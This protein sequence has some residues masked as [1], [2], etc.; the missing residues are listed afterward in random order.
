MAIS[1]F[2]IY[3]FDYLN[4]SGLLTAKGKT[5]KLEQISSILQK[6]PGKRF[7]LI[8]DDTQNDIRIYSD[9]R[10]AI[11]RQNLPGVYS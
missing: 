9:D 6:S 7:Y 4:Y 10:R 5:F 2:I 3:L 11:P 8:G 1:D